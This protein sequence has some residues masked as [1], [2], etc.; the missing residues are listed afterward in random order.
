MGIGR[1]RVHGARVGQGADWHQMQCQ[2]RLVTIGRG[3]VYTIGGE[4]HGAQGRSESVESIAVRAAFQRRF[5]Y[6]WGQLQD[7]V[8]NG[9]IAFHAQNHRS[10]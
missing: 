4:R 6:A 8:K 10:H 9:L 2:V 7:H 1:L 5:R 3:W